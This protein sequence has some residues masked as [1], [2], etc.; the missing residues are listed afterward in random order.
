MNSV[1]WIS[2]AAILGALF[3]SFLNVLIIRLPKMMQREWREDV[4]EAWEEDDFFSEHLGAIAQK[5][6]DEARNFLNETRE[7]LAFP[8]S[9]C[10]KCGH[11]LAFYENIPILSFLVLLGRCRAC[12]ERISV[13]YPMVEVSSA[14]VLAGL[15]WHIG[16]ERWEFFILNAIFFLG[17]LSLAWIDA[18]TKLLPDVLVLPLLWLG[19][20]AA[21]FEWHTLSV[22]EAV[23]GAAGAYGML[24]TIRAVSFWVLKKEGLGLGD[25]K[26]LAMLCAW[27][28]LAALPEVLVFAGLG[29]VLYFMVYKMLYSKP[30]IYL[31]FGPFLSLAAIFVWVQTYLF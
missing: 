11:H 10:V 12:G 2:V 28:G 31:P 9:H 8:A 17:L 1:M 30:L 5:K 22:S 27:L 18:R 13:M 24:W 23:L 29:A 21:V 3:G 7:N 6:R 26:L 16:V 15:A 4:I 20:L 19:L 25:V 14:V